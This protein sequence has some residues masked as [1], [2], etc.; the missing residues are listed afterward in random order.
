MVLFWVSILATVGLGLTISYCSGI[1]GGMRQIENAPLIVPD[2]VVIAIPPVMF[3]EMGLGLFFALRENI[4]T[5]TG[6]LVRVWMWIFW[7]ALF[8]TTAFTPYFVFNGMP[9]AAY[10]VASVATGL[11]VG[12]TMLTYRQSIAG[13]VMMT[14]VLAISA[15]IMIYLGYWAFA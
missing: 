11:A 15:L 3:F 5:T 10:I 1:F 9:I 13:G 6:R 12:T 8:L 14:I 4:Y 7:C 2:W